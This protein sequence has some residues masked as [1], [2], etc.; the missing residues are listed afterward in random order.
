V[1]GQVKKKISRRERRGRREKKKKLLKGITW[2]KGLHGLRKRI[3]AF[4][5]VIL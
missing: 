4:I 5:H 3:N 1:E 2:I